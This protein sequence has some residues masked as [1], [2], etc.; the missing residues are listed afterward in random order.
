[1]AGGRGFLISNLNHAQLPLT[2]ACCERLP[3][4]GGIQ[5]G[6][7][8]GCLPDSPYGTAA[9][10]QQKEILRQLGDGGVCAGLN[11]QQRIRCCRLKIRA[12]SFSARRRDLAAGGKV[13]LSAKMPPLTP[14]S[15][16]GEFC[17][18][19]I[20]PSSLQCKSSLAKCLPTD[21]Q[22]HGIT[23]APPPRGA[24]VCVGTA[25]LLATRS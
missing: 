25:P 4:Q 13:C 23:C 14:L 15:K 12:T 1:M 17:F 21:Q 10:Y 20:G 22:W 24:A 5:S 2:S 18:A 8:D 19:L 11:K 9:C 7:K 6:R 16:A 3:A